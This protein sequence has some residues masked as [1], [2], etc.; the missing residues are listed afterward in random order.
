LERTNTEWGPWTIVEATDRYWTHVKIFQT[1][2]AS[3]EERLGKIPGALPPTPAPTATVTEDLEQEEAPTQEAPRT[4]L[5]EEQA[6]VP[7]SPDKKT[8]KSQRKGEHA[9]KPE[10]EPARK[11]KRKKE[12]VEEQDRVTID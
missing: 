6:A 10:P 11:K 12:T 3:L 7:T 5:A 8:R 9:A 4:S 2:I 1:I